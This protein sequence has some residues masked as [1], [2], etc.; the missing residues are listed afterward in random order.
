[1]KVALV[2]DQIN[3][4]GGAERVLEALCE[5]YPDAPI[6]T[7]FYKKDSLAWKH[8][9]HKKIVPSWA[10]YIPF[11]STRLHSPLRFLAP[12]IWGSFNFS[13][14]DVVISSASWYITKGFGNHSPFPAI[15]Y[16]LYN[17]QQVLPQ[18]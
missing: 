17:I 3:E 13:K 7:S 9:K 4:Y 8:F 6:Y 12:W 16:A 2:H 5:L 1:M 14:Y 18:F 11:F 10:H 15:Y